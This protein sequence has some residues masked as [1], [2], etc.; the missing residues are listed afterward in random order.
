MLN[1]GIQRYDNTTIRRICE[2]PWNNCHIKCQ[3]F[4]A[5]QHLY[6]ELVNRMNNRAEIKLSEQRKTIYEGDQ[7]M[8]KEPCVSR[9]TTKSWSTYTALA[10]EQFLQRTHLCQTFQCGRILKQMGSKA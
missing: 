9:K 1:T 2:T 10:H 7:D 6:K 8:I 5:F 3:V 4:D